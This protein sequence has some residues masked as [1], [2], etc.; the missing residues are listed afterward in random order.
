MAEFFYCLK[1]EW[2]NYFN[3][4]KNIS[5][6]KEKKEY[7]CN[8]STLRFDFDMFTENEFSHPI[9]SSVDTIMVNENEKIIYLIEFKNQTCANIDNNE[10]R[11]KV[12]DSLNNL[13]VLI[14]NCNVNIKEYDLIVGIVYN[15]KKVYTY[16]NRICSSAIQFGL[17]YFKEQK[18][19]KNAVTKDIEW[20]K[21]EYLRIKRS[22]K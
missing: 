13:P 1:N 20:F 19:I 6:D 9:P 7:M 5:Y 10:V 15:D 22:I 16:R 17:G 3:T 11:K 4:L 2:G 21:K 18:R 8:C 14:K 12:H